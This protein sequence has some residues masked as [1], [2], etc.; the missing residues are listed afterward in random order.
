MDLGQQKPGVFDSSTKSE[1][2]GELANRCEGSC[3]PHDYLASCSP[4]MT[5]LG[6]SEAQGVS[7]EAFAGLLLLLT[8]TLMSA[9]QFSGILAFV[10]PSPLLPLIGSSLMLAFAIVGRN[11]CLA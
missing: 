6:E 7:A 5:S 10:G 11:A 9:A 4:P 8:P 1:A 2:L 3:T